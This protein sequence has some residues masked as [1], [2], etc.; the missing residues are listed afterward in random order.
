MTMA[1][2]GS[3][4][5]AKELRASIIQQAMTTKLLTAGRRYRFGGKTI[6]GFDC[7]GFVCFVY[8]AVFS[9]FPYQDTST[10]R[11]GSNFVAVAKAAPGDL[12]YFPPQEDMIAHVGIVI[13]DQ[14]WIGSQS[15][16]GVAVVKMNNPYWRARRS[17]FLRYRPL[18]DESG[19]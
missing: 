11:F 1:V 14:E 5:Q 4:Q 15:S 18:N 16:T 7:S 10:L 3:V 9:G 8:Q 17:E 6:A 12:I 19:F 13:S 2:D